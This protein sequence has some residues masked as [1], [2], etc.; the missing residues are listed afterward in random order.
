MTV[1]VAIIG[2]SPNAL[3]AAARLARANRS[4]VIL[5]ASEQVG[6]PLA[7]EEL[8][9]GFLA[10]TGMP[11]A[12]LDPELAHLPRLDDSAF[13]VSRRT[14]VTRLASTPLTLPEQR[15]P[16]A[17]E[18]AVALV[19]AL[20]RVTPP[21]LSAAAELSPIAQQL[22]ALDERTVHDVLR[23][24]F[25]SVR[26]FCAEAKLSDAEAAVLAGVATRGRGTGPFAPG[27]LFGALRLAAQGDAVQRSTVRGGVQQLPRRMAEAAMAS[28]CEI[29]TGTSATVDVEG[30]VATGVRLATGERIAAWA[31]LSDLDA[32]ATFTRL[33]SP[34]EIEPEVKRAL[35]SLRY[36]GTVARIHL[37]LRELP[38]FTGVDDAALRGTLVVAGD[39]DDQERAWDAAK[40]GALPARPYIELAIPTLD[41]PSLAP[42][43]QHVVDVWVQHVPYAFRDRAALLARVLDAVAPHAPGLADLVLHHHVALPHDLEA[44]FG[45]TE[46]HLYGGELSLEQAFLFRP[47]SGCTGYQTP[48]RNLYLCG[49]ASQPG[50]YTGRSGWN[51]AGG[52]I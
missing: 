49:S 18:A 38:R 20:D 44:R 19:R 37:A 35:R 33:V 50:G 27:S 15:L 40:R 39:L 31:V 47:F 32:R 43:G 52:L 10:N 5:E 14:T 17:F 11:A 41:D 6:G 36:R 48:I 45:L 21:E 34:A 4:V 16:A 23:L 28:G 42:P 51:A 22:L 1:D 26:D 25:V 2:S 9:P 13:E 24:L 3:A 29:R 46:G 12:P 30:G 7:T 8:A